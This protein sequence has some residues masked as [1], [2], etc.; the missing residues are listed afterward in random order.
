[1]NID[2][3]ITVDINEDDIRKAIAVFVE[4]AISDDGIDISI[5]PDNIVLLIPGH[6]RTTLSA[7]VVVEA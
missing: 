3:K 6:E 5:H 2:K 4:E 7:R 1:M